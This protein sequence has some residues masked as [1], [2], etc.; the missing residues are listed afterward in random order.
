M[1]YIDPTGSLRGSNPFNSLALDP[2]FQ[3]N[4]NG[5][6][7]SS[8]GGGS[9]RNNRNRRRNQ[10]QATGSIG[11]EEDAIND[12]L[13]R[14]ITETQQIRE[15]QL[16]DRDAAVGLLGDRVGQRSQEYLDALE[17][18]RRDPA[19]TPF[20]QAIRASITNTL[21]NP[22]VYTDE[23]MRDFAARERDNVG[24]SIDGAIRQSRVNDA[25]RGVA[26]SGVNDRLSQALT[27]QGQSDL[28]N[29]LGGMDLQRAQLRSQRESAAQQLGVSLDTATMQERGRRLQA[30]AGFI[31]ES[32]ARD[33][34]AVMGMADILANTEYLPPDYS[35]IASVRVGLIQASNDLLVQRENIALL[36][37]QIAS[38]ERVG[39]ASI[40]A[41]NALANARRDFNT[42]LEFLEGQL[43]DVFEQ[44]NQQD[45][46]G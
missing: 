30:L 10:G 6:N 26:Q 31:S 44:Q 36:E 34:E 9:N 16:V 14:Q 38:N 18:L 37:Q 2:N 33:L 4:I 23:Q 40:E 29:T 41:N 46:Q 17:G 32:E 39:I 12:L 13:N 7:N 42:Q 43:N 25:G 19:E 45:G 1:P 28:S 15:Q 5:N 11:D 24:Q 20:G 22:D 21:D 27:L 3:Y 8:S 35:G